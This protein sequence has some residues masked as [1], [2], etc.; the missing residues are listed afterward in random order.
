[1]GLGKGIVDVLQWYLAIP[2]EEMRDNMAERLR[3]VIHQIGTRMVACAMQCNGIARKQ[4]EGILPRCLILEDDG[5]RTG[6]GAIVCGLNPGTNLRNARDEQE[7][8]VSQGATYD[9]VVSYWQT[10]LIE[11]TYFR[12]L[13]TLVNAL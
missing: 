4:S 7:Y 11:H 13:R 12:R 6:E 9:S 10:S 2:S 1:M 5:K 3:K 8:Y